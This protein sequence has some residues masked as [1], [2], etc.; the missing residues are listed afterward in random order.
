MV[1]FFIVM[2]SNF[3]LESYQVEGL[4][5]LVELLGSEEEEKEV[6]VNAAIAIANWT[7]NGKGVR[8]LFN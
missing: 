8:I 3:L 7:R 4:V 2:L 5:K 1:S 6:K